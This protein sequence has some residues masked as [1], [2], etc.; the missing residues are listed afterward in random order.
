M[1]VGV[2][3]GRSKE[4][5]TLCPSETMNRFKGKGSR[6]GEL[7]TVRYIPED[8]YYVRRNRHG[9]KV[10]R[11]NHMTEV[12]RERTPSAKSEEGDDSGTYERSTKFCTTI[13]L[14]IE[15]HIFDL[16][17][18][19]L[20]QLLLHLQ[21]KCLFIGKRDSCPGREILLNR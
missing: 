18:T 16:L 9:T 2:V 13:M 21:I 4:Q 1:E 19:P 20:P 14:E 7:G 17:F 6:E 8:T 3:D 10:R 11:Q 15:L 5:W 12:E